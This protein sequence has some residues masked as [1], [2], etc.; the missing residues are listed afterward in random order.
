MRKILGWI[1]ALPGM[2]LFVVGT[3]ILAIAQWIGG[4]KC[5]FL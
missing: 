3:S 1:I 2:L 4:D 5:H